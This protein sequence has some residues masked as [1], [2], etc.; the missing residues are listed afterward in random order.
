M[1]GSM[2]IGLLIG[3][4]TGGVIGA[5]GIAIVSIGSIERSSRDTK[6]GLSVFL[7]SPP[8]RRAQ[9][10]SSIGVDLLLGLQEGEHHAPLSASGADDV[11]PEMRAIVRD[12]ETPPSSR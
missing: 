4:F 11:S 3:V 12:H 1:S 5:L 9:T 8:P 7:A 2:L 10:G 6:D